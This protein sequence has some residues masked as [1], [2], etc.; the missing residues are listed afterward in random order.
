MAGTLVEVDVVFPVLHGPN[1]EDGTVQ[2][3]LELSDVAYVGSRVMGSAAGVSPGLVV[4]DVAEA[5]GRGQILPY[6]PAGA[7]EVRSA[8]RAF[9]EMRNRIERQNEQRALMLSGVGHD[10]RTP[11]T[12]LK[13][14]LS[15]LSPDLPP[16]P[17]EIAD[18]ERDV[19]EMGAMIDAFLDHVRAETQ[20]AGAEQVDIR[21][22]L[23]E[24]VADAQR[25][26]QDVELTALQPAVHA[27]SRQW[28]EGEARHGAVVANRHGTPG[29]DEVVGH[30]RLVRG[31]ED[32]P[33][34]RDVLDTARRAGDRAEG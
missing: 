19:A 26:G 29:A 25:G 27:G 13:L 9:V 2:G 16:E 30:V 23:D 20:E 10:L 18:M 15:M 8:G 17:G 14:G 4:A 31:R 24:I 34:R 12:R 7:T 32:A 1:G 3:A 11:L 6:R 5:Y 22:F 28:A 33:G 21:G